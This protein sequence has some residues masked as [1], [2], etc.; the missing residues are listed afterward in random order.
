MKYDLRRFISIQEEEFEEALSEIKHGKKETHW[1]WYIFPQI[2]GLGTSSK[3]M[4]Y[5]IESIE[6]AKEYWNDVYL[7][8][9]LKE[10]TTALMN[11][12]GRT[13]YEIFGDPDVYKLKSSM[14]LFYLATNEQVFKDVLDKYYDGD[15]D[16]R[17]TSII[18]SKQ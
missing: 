18:K 8:D 9:N 1:M 17:T 3:S 2:K 5:G 15:L 16:Q 13:A 6:E 4:Y 12:E 11:L 14:T 10:I 7:R